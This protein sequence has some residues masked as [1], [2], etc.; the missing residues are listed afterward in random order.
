MSVYPPLYPPRTQVGTARG[1]SRSSV[2]GEPHHAG[3]VPS[4]AVASRASAV[5]ARCRS[6]GPISSSRRFGAPKRVLQLIDI[7]RVERV[8]DR[9]VPRSEDSAAELSH[10]LQVLAIGQPEQLGLD[11]VVGLGS[12]A[13]L[14]WT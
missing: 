9:A 14:W 8:A 2:D 11:L 4:A 10:E 13:P 3:R 7:D 5:F 12:C 6:K 1:A